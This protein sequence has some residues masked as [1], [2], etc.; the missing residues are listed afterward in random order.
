VRARLAGVFVAALALTGAVAAP[1]AASSGALPA[2][3][4]ASGSVSVQVYAASDGVLAPKTPLTVT[5]VV[6]NTASSR[7]AQGTVKLSITR[8]P[9]DNRA[10]LGAWLAP[11]ESQPTTRVL[12]SAATV[13]V[14]PGGSTSAATVTV[15]AAAVGLPAGDT[16]V[17]GISAELSV[18]GDSVATGHGTLVWKASSSTQKTKLAVV[19]P[20][21]VPGNTT[22][23]ISANDLTTYTAADGL[24][25][26][27]LDA[28]QAAPEVAVGV[29]PMIIASIRAL[30]SAAPP[31]ANDWL[32]QLA[33]LSNEVFPLQYGD[34]DV[35][36]QLQAG[37]SP[38]LKPLS[39]DYAL[40]PARFKGNLTVGETPQ[41]TGTDGAATTSTPT[42][43]PTIPT[44]V[45]TMDQL[46]AWPY[47]TTGIA[48]PGDDTVRAADVAALA[49]QGYPTTILADGNTNAAALDAAPSASVPVSGAAGAKALI[50]DSAVSEAVRAAVDAD[51]TDSHSEAM[52]ALNAQLAMIDA[53][54]AASK[55]RVLLASLDR[56]RPS[57]E[58]LAAQTFA[59]L[60]ASAWST[61]ATLTD[62]RQAPSTPGV[63]LRDKPE[64]D[65]RIAAV[66]SLIG[67]GLPSGSPS[68]GP[69]PA[70]G[71]ERALT[72]FSTL[73]SDP[74]QLTGPTRNALLALL[75]VGWQ[76]PAADW[77]T[78]V[79]KNLN[80]AQKT[81]R[82]VQIV[83]T[84][85]I[86]VTA[87]QSQIPITVINKF[88]LAVNVI[89]RAVPS[90]PRLEIDATTSKAI[91]A[92]SSG[93]VVVP[94]KARVGNG[95]LQLDLQLLSPPAPGTGAQSAVGDEQFA[96]VDVHAD[97]E[98]IGATVIGVGAV[99][100]F[101]FGIVR[102]IVRRR[103][104]RRE[105]PGPDDEPTASTEAGSPESTSPEEIG[106]PE[107]PGHGS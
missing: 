45:P 95:K 87:A 35:A 8:Q 44:N 77:T 85:P 96:Q 70:P 42:S 15:P 75:G 53:Q 78:A 84:G 23:L 5:V 69:Q 67:S 2:A 29:D 32:R 11:S 4:P 88:R 106:T 55:G 49:K 100:L 57:S 65:S 79:Q 62:A 19:T 37:I 1:A 63:T 80:G 66:H 47:S 101:G 51:T 99:L 61:P 81:I 27:Q 34:A 41:P 68:A 102:A 13:P 17:Y 107:E 22:G 6:G 14:S 16:A 74:T 33:A 92:G 36:A 52:A 86:T 21:T 39:F 104:E 54:G 59:A 20:I 105:A 18:A 38:L 30:G 90:N 83:P 43:T 46:L 103:R 64:A 58:Y 94:V 93:K 50:A 56:T 60:R 98:G 40:D 26:R 97:W 24:L 9:F 89:L 48:W 7:L 71:G 31:T 91:S 72:D 82:S 25:T 28:V 10:E 12:Q 3:D 76:D 73:L